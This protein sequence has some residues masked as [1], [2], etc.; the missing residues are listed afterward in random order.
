MAVATIGGDG[1]ACI[2]IDAQGRQ[3]GAGLIR[4][5]H[6]K[7]HGLGR[8]RGRRHAGHRAHVD[9]RRCHDLFAPA[10]GKASAGGRKILAEHS[11]SISR[12]SYHRAVRWEQAGDHR[13]PI[14]FIEGEEGSACDCRVRVAAVNG[15]EHRGGHDCV[16]RRRVTCESLRVN[17]ARGGSWPA[18]AE[19]AEEGVLARNLEEVVSPHGERVRRAP[20]TSRRRYLCHDW[21]SEVGELG[22]LGRKR[23]AV[24]RDTHGDLLEDQRR[25]HRWRTA[26]HLLHGHERCGCR[27]M[28]A[29]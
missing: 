1:L 18:L 27:T 14:R 23:L 2:R 8:H 9:K 19:A 3:G 6:R 10:A 29:V 17:E 20:V 24:G 22:H 16:D 11:H 28:L 15:D 7:W 12:A 13:W 5:G 21:R 4:V 26:A 25:R